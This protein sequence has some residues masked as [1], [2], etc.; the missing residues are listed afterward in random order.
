MNRNLC[1]FYT[2]SELKSPLVSPSNDNIFTICALGNEVELIDS[3]SL[4]ESVTT[5]IEL[6]FWSEIL[7][8]RRDLPE[9][10]KSGVIG[11]G[12]GRTAGGSQFHKRLTS[13]DGVVVRVDAYETRWKPGRER[14]VQRRCGRGTMGVKGCGCVYEVDLGTAYLL[15]VASGCLLFTPD[16]SGKE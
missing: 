2:L 12:V 3:P 10:V 13:N 1:L 5:V 8:L 6:R 16:Y 9:S 4:V 14:S 15:I 11:G 7:R